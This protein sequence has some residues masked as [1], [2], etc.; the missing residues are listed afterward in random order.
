MQ[1]LKRISLHITEKQYNEIHQKGINLSGLVR[2]LIDDYLSENKV[3]L[4]VDDKTKQL[5]DHIISHTGASD[6][7]LI[8]PLRSAL[9][10]LLNKKIKF[11]KKLADEL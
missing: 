11:M 6:M 3:I 7:D 1:E 4:S 10:V 8:D 2:D 5:Y 9:K